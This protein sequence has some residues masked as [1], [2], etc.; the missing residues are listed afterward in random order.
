MRYTL[1]LT[2]DQQTTGYEVYKQK[3]GLYQVFMQKIGDN[4]FL[5]KAFGGKRNTPDFF[6]KFTNSKQGGVEMSA[7]ERID[8]YVDA[9]IERLEDRKE[10]VKERREKR[11]IPSMLK[12]GD[13]LYSS[14][15]YE[16][17]NV[18]F[19]QVI[20]TSGERTVKVREIASEK[21]SDNGPTTHVIARKDVFLSPRGEW[22]DTGK[23]MTRR[24]ADG[25]K[26]TISE[27]QSGWLWDGK[28][29][30]ETGLGWGH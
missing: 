5:V 21:V 30:Y 11:N 16:Q 14:W 13:I 27:C 28:P 9:W 19:Y 8:N 1:K 22:D 20:E 2:R 29:Q 6:Y 10:S 23:V 26:V 18:N 4:S 7:K 17:T 25:N 24:V 3:E 12:I 15:G